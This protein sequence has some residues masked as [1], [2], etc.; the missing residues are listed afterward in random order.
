MKKIEKNAWAF[1]KHDNPR[2]RSIYPKWIAFNLLYWSGV[3]GGIW[4]LTECQGVPIM[5]FVFIAFPV[6]MIG[7]HLFG[8]IFNAHHISAFIRS[9]M[10]GAKVSDWFD[11]NSVDKASQEAYGYAFPDLA[12]GAGSYNWAL[13]NPDSHDT[14]NL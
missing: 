14:G 10:D 5:L 4:Y 11:D 12:W 13:K 7:E 8:R 6:L 3:A 2:H 9:E 1:R